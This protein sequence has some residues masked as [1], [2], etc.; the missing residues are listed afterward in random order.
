VNPYGPAPR[1][2]AIAARTAH[3]GAMAMYLGSRAFGAPDSATRR[4]RWATTVTGAT[5]LATEIAHSP[6]N[7]PHQSRGVLTIAHVGILPAGH[8]TPSMA[9]PVAVAALLLGAIG[10]HLPR[11]IRRW[12]VLQRRVVP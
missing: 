12:S 8:L 9:L 6:G 7:W 11:S 2:V 4:W 3:L 10:S 1:A 5:L